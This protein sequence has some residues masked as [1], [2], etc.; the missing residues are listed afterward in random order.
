MDNVTQLHKAPI[1]RP[2]GKKMKNKGNVLIVDDNTDLLTAIRLLLKRH[3]TMVQTLNDPT[4][5]SSLLQQTDF[6]VVLLDMNFSKDAISGKEGLYWLE[7]LLDINPNL[8]IVI[9]TAYADIKLAVTAI[10]LGASDFIAKPCQNEELLATVAAAFK[11]VE[12]KKAIKRMTRQTKGLLD[13]INHDR[14][15][16][17]GKS[18]VMEKIFSTIAKVAGTDA[19]VLIL[20]ESG[21]GKELVARAIHNQSQRA[22]NAFISV[23][24][25]SIVGSLFESELFGHKIGAFTDAKTN[26]IGRFELAKGGS[27]FLDELG[28]LELQQQAKLLTAIQNNQVQAVGSSTSIKTDVRLICATNEN[29]HNFIVEGLFRQDLLY[30]INTIEINLPPLRERK[31]DIP[32]LINHF[33]QLNCQK[34]HRELMICQSDMHRLTRYPWPGNVRELSHSL[35]RAVILAD[36]SQIDISTIIGNKQT[37]IESIAAEDTQLNLAT[38]E[39]QTIRTAIIHFNGNLSKAAPALGL[40][41]GA[42]YRRLE[43]Y[44]I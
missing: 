20:G 29:L 9:M 38:V 26:R 32:L 5:L 22:D 25:G 42:L 16:F 39:A 23:D 43:K 35:E 15:E 8:I 12:S 1:N 6:D 28:N 33:L 36:K 24:L 4:Q 19:N 21:T 41:R 27:L 34:Y 2:K 31:E 10:K 3:Y 44:G 7:T 37:A 18:V 30:R 14:Q 13:V 40:T 11:H 17:L